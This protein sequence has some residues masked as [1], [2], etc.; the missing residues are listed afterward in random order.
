MTET[1]AIIGAGLIGRAWSIVFARAGHPVALYDID[2]KAAEAS[3]ATIRGNL[4]D[5]AANGLID[6]AA[7]VLARIK[8]AATLKDALGGAAYVQENGPENLGIKREIFAAL[9]ALAPPE[10][11]LA[12]SSSALST[13]LFTET[14]AG[15]SR[16]LVVHPV[17]PPYLLPLVELSPAPWTDAATVERSRALMERVGQVPVVLR[18]EIPGFLLNRLQGALLQEA[19]RLVDAGY[20]S[21]EDIDKTIKDGLGLRWSF[22]GPFETIDLNA[23][24][25]IADYLRRYGPAYHEM[26]ETASGAEMP[27]SAALIARI[28][29]ER[30]ESLPAGKL[31]ERQAWRDRRLMALL[32]HKRQ[33]KEP[34]G[35]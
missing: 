5:L 25:G 17:N 15:R 10:T 30:R 35:E 3:L 1:I 2:P 20:A 18:R 32:V 11:V 8:P 14:L 13:S 4:D 23:P 29:T 21:L 16:C 22:M 19:F 27:W 12:S 26:A 28:E 34:I 6:D 31:D 7:A 9:D 33:Q 24:G